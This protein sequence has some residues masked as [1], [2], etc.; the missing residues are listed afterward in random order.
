M[1]AALARIMAAARDVPPAAAQM[2]GEGKSQE[3]GRRMEGTSGEGDD[4]LEITGAREAHDIVHGETGVADRARPK[5]GE[6]ETCRHLAKGWCMRADA[7]RFAQPG[8]VVPRRVPQDLLL[9]LKAIARV[10][11]LP[12]SRSDRHEGLL[13][14]VVEAAHAGGLPAVGYAVA[15]EGR[16]LWPMAL[17]CGV[18]T[19][20]TPFPVVPWRD[21]VTLEEA[22][23]GWVCTWH[24][25][26]AGMDVHQRQ[27]RAVGTY[28]SWSLP[29]A[30][31][32][33]TQWWDMALSWARDGGAVAA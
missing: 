33:C 15:N 25:H 4:G 21:M 5:I 26:P 32:T 12:F 2:E 18:A 3:S 1:E 20:L 30:G 19:L 16:I 23:L 13:H 24:T 28:L 17:P 27:S 11:A 10:G 14:D 6:V 31:V 29:T 8:P 9:I 7:C 22:S